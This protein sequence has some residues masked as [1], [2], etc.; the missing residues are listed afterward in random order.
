M[1]SIKHATNAVDR[2]IEGLGATE[3]DEDHIVPI[4][5]LEEAQAGTESTKL[6][7]PERTSQAIT[8][9]ALQ[10]TQNLADLD[11][12]STALENLGLSTT[13]S[14]QFLAIQL[15]EEVDT[16]LSRASAGDMAIEGNIV[17]RAGGT[18]VA[19]ADGGT[20]VSLSDPGADRIM[21][22]DDSAGAV[23]W[24]VPG[25]TL[26][27]TGTTLDIVNESIVYGPASA[28]D[29][30]IPRYDSTTGKLLQTSAA[31]I[32]DTGV[33]RSNTGSNEVSVPL[34]NWLMQTADRTLTSTTAEQKVFDETSNG[35]L[36][37]PTGFYEFECFIY[38]TNMSATS[39][40]FRFEPTGSGTAT[41]D[42]QVF[43]AYGI[44]NNSP[45]AAQALQGSFVAL[46]DTTA[47]SLVSPATGTQ[48]VVQIRGVLRITAGGT[49]IPTLA[50]VTAA[51]ATLK[52]G[53]YFKISKIGESSENFVGAWT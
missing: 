53:S 37:L 33:I 6:M 39:G 22:W 4:A 19:L 34:T 30:T 8:Q 14:P 29:N 18:D 28:V 21:F 52:A 40:N 49:I 26:A 46:S 15:G 43:H 24:L 50:L 23:T 17:Y 27:I 38:V 41:V 20:G 44:D 48:A 36:T 25:T 11:N 32:S 7:T 35:T 1:V 12:V 13:D 10:I 5:T 51:A 2:P 3:W 45:L 42:R 47:A 16:T 9:L 31:S